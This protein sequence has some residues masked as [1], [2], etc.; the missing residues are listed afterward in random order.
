MVYYLAGPM[1]GRPKFN[2]PAFDEAAAQ[3]RKSGL[4][5]QSPAE[6]DGE[7]TR[8]VA[9]QS[10]VGDLAEFK[11]KTDETW[12]DFL[13]RDVKMIA[14]TDIDAI[15]LLPEWET[16]NGARLETF[17]CMTLGYPVYL[18]NADGTL[19]AQDYKEVIKNMT[20]GLLS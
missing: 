11:D 2:Y 19:G 3:L 15:V 17:V 6:I 12:G 13:S 5:I 10:T 18:Y 8:K 4:T 1:S 9:M 16:S 20:E 14:D 7:E